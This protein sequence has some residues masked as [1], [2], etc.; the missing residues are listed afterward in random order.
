MGIVDR[1]PGNDRA[2]GGFQCHALEDEVH[3][4]LILALHA[5]QVGTDV[6][7]LAAHS[8]GMWRFLAKASTQRR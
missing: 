1:E 8:R 2:E 4:E 5:S 3:S 7:L 6:V